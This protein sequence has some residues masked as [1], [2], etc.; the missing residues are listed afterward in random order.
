MESYTDESAAVILVGN[1]CDGPKVV[2]DDE[3]RSFVE[4][5]K[6]HYF[7][8]SAKNSTNVSE[9]FVNVAQT[10]TE[11]KVSGS[12][13]PVGNE[14]SGGTRLENNLEEKPSGK[15]SC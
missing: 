1:K 4:S 12:K 15:C 3:I 13:V 6:L 14:G 9:M 11:K 2:P 7:E 10:L 5:K 8:T